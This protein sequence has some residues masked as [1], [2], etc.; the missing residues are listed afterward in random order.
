MLYNLW[1]SKGSE[2]NTATNVLALAQCLLNTS[3]F[4]MDIDAI[5][6]EIGELGRQQRIYGACF[7][8]MNGYAAFHMLQVLNKVWRA[9][10]VLTLVFW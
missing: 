5:F 2:I 7:C 9:W 10:I 1:Q 4:Q 6:I 8:L 3:I